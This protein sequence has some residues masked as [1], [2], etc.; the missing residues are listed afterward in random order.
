MRRTRMFGRRK[1]IGWRGRLLIAF[2]AVVLIAAG[3]VFVPAWLL[4]PAP[5]PAGAAA[6]RILIEKHAHRL[7]LY[8]RQQALRGYDVALGRGG[9]GPK[10]RDGDGKTPEGLYRVRAKLKTSAF[11]LALKLDYPSREDIAKA[12]QRGDA[13]GGDIEIHGL[14]DAVGWIGGWHRTFDWTNG[15]IALTNDEMDELWRTVPEGTAVEI[16]T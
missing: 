1:R 15:C 16:K 13:P 8:Y 14:R 9:L 10:L 3:M 12:K 7:T 5:L 6:D 2:L 11:H 4:K